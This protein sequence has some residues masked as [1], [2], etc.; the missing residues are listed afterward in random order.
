MGG[1]LTDVPNPITH[2]AFNVSSRH[3]FTTTCCWMLRTYKYKMYS[4]KKKKSFG[5]EICC[6]WTH[7]QR[8]K[9]RRWILRVWGR[10]GAG[11]WAA[12]ETRAEVEW[13]HCGG[14]FSEKETQ[15]DGSGADCWAELHCF[16]WILVL[17]YHVD[18]FG[19]IN[20]KDRAENDWRGLSRTSTL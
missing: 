15:V 20:E 7:E 6:V 3:C 13:S 11:G 1:P 4:I 18:F 2:A 14:F 9:V 19:V 16:S 8:H 17:K 12:V 10:R 5:F